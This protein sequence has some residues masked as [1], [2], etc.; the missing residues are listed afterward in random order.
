MEE[1]KKHALPT[2]AYTTEESAEMA[3]LYQQHEASTDTAINEIIAGNTSI[4]EFDS[5][6]QEAEKNYL[7]RILEIQNDA[8][9]RYL[10]KVN[11]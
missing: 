7:G 10:K 2:L 1:A 9:K 3:T 11:G 5:I 8:Y 6:T 4:D